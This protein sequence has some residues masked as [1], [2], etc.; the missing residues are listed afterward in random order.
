M[1]EEVF[2]GSFHIGKEL[3][4]MRAIGARPSCETKQNAQL[5]HTHGA[6]ALTGLS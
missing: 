1:T 3:W 5:V 2:I 6:T 4:M